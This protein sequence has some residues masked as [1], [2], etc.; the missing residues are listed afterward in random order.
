M[1]QAIILLRG[2]HRIFV[3]GLNPVDLEHELR[4]F[5]LNNST[6]EGF[7]IQGENYPDNGI[8]VYPDQVVALVARNI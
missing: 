6:A 8:V 3:Q 5:R 7:Y 1:K 4:E 2:G